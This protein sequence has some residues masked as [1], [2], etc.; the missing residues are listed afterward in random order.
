MV[1]KRLYIGQLYLGASDFYIQKKEKLNPYAG[2]SLSSFGPS[3]FYLEKTIYSTNNYWNSTQTLKQETSL[4]G[5]L[6][7]ICV[8]YLTFF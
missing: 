2:L 8:L 6:L 4:W 3:P 7:L 1:F 5:N